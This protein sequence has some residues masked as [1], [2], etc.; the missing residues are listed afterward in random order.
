MPKKRGNN[1]GSI[2]KRSDG[3]WMARVT[4]GRNPDTGKLQRVSLYGKTREAVAEA[5]SRALSDK[6]RGAFVRPEK[7]TLGE[8]L[9]MW[10]NDYKKPGVRPATYDTYEVAIRCHIKSLVGHI[11]LKDL[12]PENLQWLYN[13]KLKAGLSPKWIRQIHIV[14]HGALK[15]AIK[16]QLVVRNVS[17]ATIL[18]KVANKEIQPLTL[19]EVNRLLAVIKEDR[20]YPAIL[21][22]FGTGLRRGE[23]LALRWQD[24]DLQAGLLYVRQSLVRVGNHTATGDDRKTRLIFQEPKTPQSRRT[25]PLAEDILEEIKRHKARVAQEKLFLSPGLYQDHGLIFCRADGRPLQ[26]RSFG[27]YFA[28]IVKRAGLPHFRFHDARHT[29]ATLMLELGESPK[30]VQTMLGHS[31]IAI[32]MDLYSHV[33]LE[34]EKR[35]MARLGKALRG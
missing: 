17:E 25:I 20:L 10:L 12:R 22:E 19:D 7:V 32:T 15:Q 18:P 31:N 29:F 8:W 26:P 21:L 9:D 16:N 2:T 4:V 11:P 13:E 5:M 34:L 33:S 1:E 28:G 24:V 14:L 23:L 30:T 6:S 3:R 35:A 27:K